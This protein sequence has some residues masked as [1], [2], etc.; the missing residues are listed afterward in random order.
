MKKTFRYAIVVIFII[1][2][3]ITPPDVISQIAVALPIIALY[4][5]SIWLCTFIEKRK[6]KNKASD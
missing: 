2:A 3:L 5:I 4:S 1:S 6:I